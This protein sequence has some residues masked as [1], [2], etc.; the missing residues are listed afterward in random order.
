MAE[1]MRRKVKKGKGAKESQGTDMSERISQ[2]GC[3]AS[4]AQVELAEG[5]KEEGRE[6]HK[7]DKGQTLLFVCGMY[8]GRVG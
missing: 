7:V 8:G 3:S 4:A 6:G 1:V 5:M 2:A